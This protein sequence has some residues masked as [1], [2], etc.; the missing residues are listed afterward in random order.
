[1]T[2]SVIGMTV[3]AL[4][5]SCV[6]VGL[7]MYTRIF[8][9]ESARWDDWT[10]VLALVLRS[11]LGNPSTYTNL[12]KA[13][14]HYR[15]WFGL[16]RNPLRLRTASILPQRSPDPRVQEIRLWRMDSDFLHLDG[17]LGVDLSA[18]TTYLSQQAHHKAHPVPR[19]IPGC[20]EHR[21]IS[22]LDLAMLPSGWS[23]GCQEA[24]D[25]KVFYKGSDPENHHFPSQ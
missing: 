11:L 25:R 15:C 18:P 21:T 4:T 6:F 9:T 14:Y 24:R 10:I 7:R 3:G 16:S 22:S 2:G 12:D 17:H 5:L 19:V 13:W 8:L 20:I 23:L 1:M